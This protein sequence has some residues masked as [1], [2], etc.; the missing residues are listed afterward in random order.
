LAV[1]TR[2]KGLTQRAA[3]GWNLEDRSQI[4]GRCPVAIDERHRWVVPDLTQQV[5][6]T[7]LP[8]ARCAKHRVIR[9]EQRALRH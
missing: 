7:G 3:N 5:V 6:S 2:R 8:G 1:R 4:D 9:A